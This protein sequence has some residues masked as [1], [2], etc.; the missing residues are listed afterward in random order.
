MLTKEQDDSLFRV[1]EPQVLAE[2]YGM[3]VPGKPVTDVK[4][5]ETFWFEYHLGVTNASNATADNNANKGLYGRY[6]MRWYGQSLGVF[7]FYANDIYGDDI[8][9][10]ASVANGG[11]M[12]GKSSS[13]SHLR[14]GPDLTLSGVPYGFPFWLENQYMYVN[15]NNPT[16]FDKSFT[17]QG[18]FHQ[19]NAQITG[20]MVGYGRYDWIKGRLYDDTSSIVNSVMGVTKTKPEEYDIVAGL[21]YAIASNVKL[22]G[23][24]RY[25]E[26]KDTASSPNTSK[27][28]DSGFTTRIMFGF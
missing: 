18:G 26:F 6:V 22:I 2:V 11:I 1:S 4:S 15:E 23:E 13:N 8:R 5:K 3:V 21:Q 7:A 27:L 14:I 9:S 25:H 28:N 19:L 16:G 12:S 20:K 17:W 10:G 24:Y